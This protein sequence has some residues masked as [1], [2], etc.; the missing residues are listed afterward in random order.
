MPGEIKRDKRKEEGN[1]EENKET[2][3]Y[4]LVLLGRAKGSAFFSGGGSGF[5]LLFCHQISASATKVQIKG[6]EPNWKSD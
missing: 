5:L 2:P 6:R 1:T 3:Q 4:D